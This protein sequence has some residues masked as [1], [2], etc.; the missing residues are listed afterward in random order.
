[1]EEDSNS[2]KRRPRSFLV[3]CC[4]QDRRRI[5]TICF[6]WCSFFAAIVCLQ[7]YAVRKRTTPFEYDA[8]EQSRQERSLRSA[9]IQ[10][11]A[12]KRSANVPKQ[13]L[14][15]TKKATTTSPPSDLPSNPPP[16]APP[17]PTLPTP[18]TPP[19]PPTSPTP[20][21]PPSPPTLLTPLTPP[22]PPPTPPLTP[23]T[24]PA[25]TNSPKPDNDD[26]VDEEAAVQEV[27]REWHDREGHDAEEDQR[28]RKFKPGERVDD[29]HHA[30][31]RDVHRDET[32]SMPRKEKKKKEK[33]KKISKRPREMPT[34]HTFNK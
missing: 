18:P 1:M 11:M 32:H 23:L 7:R 15:D 26:D 2:K 10:V 16:S 30:A 29:V 8:T 3:S 21:A 13:R 4:R 33:E 28:F 6:L 9:P 20:P 17:L 12:R 27:L 19:T 31:T 25:Q 5:Y 34:Y 24:P 22:T 14:L